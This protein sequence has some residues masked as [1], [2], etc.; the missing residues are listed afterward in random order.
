MLAVVTT[1]IKMFGEEERVTEYVQFV[2]DRAFNDVNYAIDGSKLLALGWSPQVSWAEGLRRTMD[3][4]CS[5]DVSRHWE[6]GIDHVLI[7][8]PTQKVN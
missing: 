8:H 7:P 4:Y 1:L 5:R 6:A 3:W 2:K